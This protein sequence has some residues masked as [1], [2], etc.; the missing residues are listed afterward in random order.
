[1]LKN[2]DVYESEVLLASKTGRMREIEIVGEENGKNKTGKK[3]TV[4]IGE[5]TEGAQSGS[6]NGQRKTDLKEE[7]RA[8]TRH[9][10][11]SSQGGQCD[12]IQMNIQHKA[13]EKDIT[14][15]YQ[16]KS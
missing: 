6:G 7:D 10:S 1:M 2:G 3:V 12:R 15:P 14:M 8:R 5:T 13:K 16:E 11:N 4:K 9:N